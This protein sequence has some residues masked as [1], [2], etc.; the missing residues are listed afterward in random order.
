[1]HGSACVA[2]DE[3][4]EDGQHTC[5]CDQA[6]S[7]V[8]MYAGKYC[9][10][11]STD[12]CTKSGKPGVGRANFAFCVNDGVCKSKVSDNEEYVP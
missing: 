6:T 5:N 7:G 8:E 10:Y 2:E 12:I 9:Q 4:G 11:T 3:V 1:L